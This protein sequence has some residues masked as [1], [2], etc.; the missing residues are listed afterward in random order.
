MKKFI[1]L[2]LFAFTLFLFACSENKDY[3]KIINQESTYNFSIK[4]TSDNSSIILED[5]L[6]ENFEVTN[7]ESPVETKEPDISTLSDA[8]SHEITVISYPKRIKNGETATLTIKGLPNTEYSIKVYYSSGASKAAGLENKISDSN[9]NVSWKWRIGSRTN[10]G[11][12]KIEISGKDV[13][14]VLYFTTYK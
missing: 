7:N 6:T 14:T 4:E 12:H 1:S 9:G 8:K 11:E 3:V 5:T 13:S 2:I 10:E